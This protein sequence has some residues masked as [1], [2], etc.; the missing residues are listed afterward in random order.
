MFRLYGQQ[1]LKHW[2]QLKG[3]V[4]GNQPSWEALRLTPHF[5]AVRA[6]RLH[7]QTFTPTDVTCALPRHTA[8]GLE[9]LLIVEKHL[10]S[11]SKDVV[12]VKGTLCTHTTPD[13]RGTACS[14][15]YPVNYCLAYSPI[16]KKFKL[17]LHE[18]VLFLYLLK[19][20]HQ[21][22]ATPMLTH[23]HAQYTYRISSNKH[24]STPRTSTSMLQRH[25][26]YWGQLWK[27][28]WSTHQFWSWILI[29]KNV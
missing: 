4:A 14:T 28:F 17:L 8:A 26:T 11:W 12:H 5:A 18:C 24:N 3:S 20:V 10:T 27:T 23:N 7:H 25:R 19:I 21:G 15:L 22:K 13:Q 29:H 2:P 1:S 9:V 6:Q 16:S